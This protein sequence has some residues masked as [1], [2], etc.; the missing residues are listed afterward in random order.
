MGYYL[1]YTGR[2]EGCAR[3]LEQESAARGNYPVLSGY[4]VNADRFSKALTR[5]AGFRIR[6][7]AP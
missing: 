7:G 5:R 1:T 6:R 2:Q 3:F 4:K